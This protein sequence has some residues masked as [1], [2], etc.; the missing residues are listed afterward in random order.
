[1]WTKQGKYDEIDV[2]DGE[3]ITTAFSK[4]N[5]HVEPIQVFDWR[6]GKGKWQLAGGELVA[7]D[8]DHFVFV[9]PDA[10]DG[11]TLSVVSRENP[12]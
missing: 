6:T 3:M 10:A 2:V 4:A 7:H 8:D 12:R 11:P 9:D 1:M 5:G